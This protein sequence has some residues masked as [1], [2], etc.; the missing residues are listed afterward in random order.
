MTNEAVISNDND[1]QKK[2]LVTFL[3]KLWSP[4]EK[5][6]RKQLSLQCTNTFDVVL[7]ETI[8]FLYEKKFYVL[9]SHKEKSV[10]MYVIIYWKSLQ[11]G[12]FLNGNGKIPYLDLV[13]WE[14]I[15]FGKQKN[16]CQLTTDDICLLFCLLFILC[17]LMTFAYCSAC[18][19]F[20]VP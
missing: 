5:N 19:L 18:Y 12:E 16:S 15:C 7:I 9:G 4:D 11:W 13:H 8:E 3:Q 20:Y 17:S 14:D 1:L 2:G 10:I 6:I